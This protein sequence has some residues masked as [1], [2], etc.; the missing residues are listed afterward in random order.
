MHPSTLLLAHKAYTFTLSPIIISYKIVLEDQCQNMDAHM[1]EN[2]PG[3]PMISN[4]HYLSISI[5]E[6]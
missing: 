2:N 6:E 3:V 5:L 4:I 1:H